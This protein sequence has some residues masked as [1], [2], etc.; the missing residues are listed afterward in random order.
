MIKNRFKLYGKSETS[1][2][3]VGNETAKVITKLI[4]VIKEYIEAYAEDYPFKNNLY[5]SYDPVSQILFIGADGWTLILEAYEGADDHLMLSTAAPTLC[6]SVDDELGLV[7]V[8]RDH[9]H[10]LG[11]IVRG[12]INN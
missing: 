7:Q 9:R 12:T 8:I 1:L 10:E 5:I 4:G 6:L 2:R 3:S 11:N